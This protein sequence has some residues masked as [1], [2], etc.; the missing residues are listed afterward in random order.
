VGVDLSGAMLVGA[1]A[2]GKHL[3]IRFDDGRT[4]HAHLLMSGSFLVGPTAT[5]PVWRRRLELWFDNGRLTAIDVPLLAI[6][7]GTAE[8]AVVGHLGPDLCGP[9]QPDLML[10]TAN[11]RQS[12]DTPLA[13]ALLDQRNAAGWGNVYAVE[14]PFITGVS[15]NQPVGS[16]GNLLSLVGVGVALIRNNTSRGRRNTTGRRLQSADHW[17]Y[18][19]SGGSCPLCGARLADWDARTSPWDRVAVWCPVCQP[20][21]EPGVTRDVDAV[22]AVRLLALHPARR[23]VAFGAVTT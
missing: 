1:D 5:Q 23:E 11:L 2:V 19:K 8:A 16:I 4:M 6:V 18:G 22:R 15:P 17:V 14:L 9:A 21:A 10:V 13:A 20:S 3:L 7:A 12:P